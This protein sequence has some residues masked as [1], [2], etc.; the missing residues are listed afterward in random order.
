VRVVQIVVPLDYR[1][2]KDFIVQAQ[3]VVRQLRGVWRQSK[4]EAFEKYST[5]LIEKMEATERLI[6]AKSDPSQ[7]EGAAKESE[8]ILVSRFGL[9]VQRAG[10]GKGVVEEVALE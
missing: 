2:A 3:Q 8:D 9:S 1:Q 6:I 5:A 7:V 4:A 10:S